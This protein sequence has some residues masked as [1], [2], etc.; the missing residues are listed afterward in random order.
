MKTALAE[1]TS[2]IDQNESAATNLATTSPSGPAEIAQT[3]RHLDFRAEEPPGAAIAPTLE[4]EG[5]SC[6]R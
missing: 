2:E 5:H 4:T 3:V 1:L 6:C